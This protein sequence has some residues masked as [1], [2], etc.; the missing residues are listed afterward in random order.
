MIVGLVR[1][2][3]ITFSEKKIYNMLGGRV[4][5]LLMVAR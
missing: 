4:I 3:K 2:R 5:L 1:I